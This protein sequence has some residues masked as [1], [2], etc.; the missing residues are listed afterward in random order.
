MALPRAQ[1]D[2]QPS[3]SETPPFI[4]QIAQP[5]SQ[6]DISRS[7]RLI[8]DHLRSAEMIWQARRSERPIMA[9][10]CATASR[11]AAGPTIF[12]PEAHEARPQSSICSASSFFS[13]A[14]SSSSAFSRLA[15]E[16]SM[17]PYFGPS[18]YKMSLLKSRACGKSAA[19]A[20]ASFSFST[21]MICSSVKSL[22][23][24]PSVLNGPDSNQFW[25]KF[26]VGRSAPAEGESR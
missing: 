19:F 12:L 4:G 16:T 7:A 15:S 20:P 10:R 17:P 13:L 26:S 1:Q 22:L 9:F 14:F 21:A 8:T 6:L 18:S 5:Q 25:R 24:H 23:L 2:E 11:L 3:V